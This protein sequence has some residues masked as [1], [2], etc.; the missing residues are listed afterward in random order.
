MPQRKARHASKEKAHPRNKVKLVHS[1]KEFFDLLK[2]LIDAASHSIHIQTYIFAEDGTG[3]SIAEALIDAAKR[4]VEVWLVVDGFASQGLSKAFIN[5]LKEAGVNVRFF[6]PLFRSRNFYFGR[7][8]H[9]KIIVVDGVRALTGSMNIADRYNDLPGKP[10]WY[11]LALYVEGETAVDLYWFCCRSWDRKKRFKVPDAIDKV[12]A[13]IPENE[14]CT[15][16][17][18]KNDWVNRKLQIS[19]SYPRLVRNAKERVTVISSY[20]LPT[21]KFLNELKRAVK[22]G[23]EVKIVLTKVS[24]IRTAKYAER[25]LYRWMFRNNIRIYEYKP[26]VLHAKLAIA[27]GKELTLGSYNVNHLSDHVSVELNLDVKCREFVSQVEKETDA[28]IKNDCVEIESREYTES[29]L[30]FRQF[31]QWA[32]YQFLRL[33]LTIFTF[34]FRQRD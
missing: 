21:R 3:T 8:M 2:Q 23:V 7:R 25:Y 33:M 15:V 30:S 31:F 12:I 11:D 24:D 5:K 4:N 26:T 29:L 27:D 16:E 13:S 22:R 32:A 20:F 18:Q 1:G 6:E 10:A 28:I 34:Y 19:K 17:I 9:H 14:F